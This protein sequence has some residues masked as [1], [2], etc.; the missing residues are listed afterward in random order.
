MKDEIISLCSE[1][2]S[3]NDA[4][5]HHD[6]EMCSLVKRIEELT[7]AVSAA[8]EKLLASARATEDAE[9]DLAR[10][11][12]SRSALEKV[13][14]KLKEDQS[15]LQLQV[16]ALNNELAAE[17]FDHFNNTSQDANLSSLPGAAGQ[18]T[19]TGRARNNSSQG[20]QGKKQL[21]GER[22]RAESLI[23]VDLQEEGG[24]LLPHTSQSRDG[25]SDYSATAATTSNHSFSNAGQNRSNLM[26]VNEVSARICSDFIVH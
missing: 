12:T 24:G 23:S 17:K 5:K 26:A 18:S 3:L 11:N 22:D 21:G 8:E 13:V 10:A 20:S 19:S 16:E 4:A 7:C 25:E 14:A 1:I 6:G 15:D 2:E 9:S